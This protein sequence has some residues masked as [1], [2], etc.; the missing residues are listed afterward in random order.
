M[1]GHF[2]M[3][4][5]VLLS[6][7]GTFLA[8]RAIAQD[9]DPKLKPSWEFMQS[10]MPGVPYETLKA[11]C[12]EGRVMIYHGSWTDAQ[13]AQIDGFRKRFP[14]I[15]VQKFGTTMGEMRERYLS[16]ARAGR[17][18]A[19]IVQ[20]SDPGTLDT[21]SE[22]GL[23]TSYTI[24]YD[25]AYA[26]ATKKGGFWYPLRIAINGI[27]WNTDIVSDEEAKFLTSWEGLTDPRWKGR[28]VIV[29][30][31]GGGVVYLPFY[32]WEKMYGPD[33]LEKIGAQRP[34]VVSGINTAAAALASGDVAI[35][36]NASETGLLP[37]WRKGAPI[38]WSIPSPAVGP[39]TGQ[40]IAGKPPH[41]NAARLYQE[42]AF[43][44]E[45]YTAWYMLGGMPVRS[46]L[47]DQR[48]VASE[49]WYMYPNEV[50]AYDTRDSEQSARGIIEKFGRLI[51]GGKK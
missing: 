7:A 2:S 30:P 13:N 38:R 46:G 42:Y 23:F 1:L 28:G 33:F 15:R 29:D 3:R 40:A 47:K 16:E 5:G 36:F 39:I 21:N 4:I 22:K 17:Q 45:G 11:A 18:V 44:T 26:P 51:G 37:I 31:S 9:I 50:W 35:I 24:S 34:R 20:D 27:A 25:A 32:A 43:T 14:C 49:P 6:A 10:A 8:P 19:D 48:K 41:Q 12:A